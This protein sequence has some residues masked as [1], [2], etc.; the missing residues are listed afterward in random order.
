[1]FSTHARLDWLNLPISY[2]PPQNMRDELK[3]FQLECRM[4][5]CHPCKWTG[6]LTFHGVG[7]DPVMLHDTPQDCFR[8]P[9]LAGTGSNWYQEELLTPL[10]TLADAAN[11]SWFDQF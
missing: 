2:R 7:E 8:I 9:V 6:D 5:A 11:A 4:N 10:A 3:I 1:M